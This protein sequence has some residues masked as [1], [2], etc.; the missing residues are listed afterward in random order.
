M[1]RTSGTDILLTRAPDASEAEADEPLSRL[2]RL[3]EDGNVEAARS[4]L[5]ALLDRW[6]QSP[7]VQYWA[8]VL[9]PPEVSI[10][11][12]QTTRSFDREHEWLRQHRREYPGCW[13]AV[14]ADR[15][16]AADPDLERVYRMTRETL[17]KEPA[18]IYFEGPS[19]S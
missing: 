2:R 18:L 17:G 4:L 1:S 15:L 3:V 8:R 11:E 14:H 7:R 9:A 16:I 19:S 10:V 13:I 5:A 6:P 12:G